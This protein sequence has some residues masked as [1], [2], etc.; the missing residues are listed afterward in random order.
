MAQV[1]Y[2]YDERG[3]SMGLLAQRQLAPALQGTVAWTLGAEHGVAVGLAR[4]TEQ[5]ALESELKVPS[6]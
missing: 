1:S 6:P 3:F 2:K 4:H 5:W